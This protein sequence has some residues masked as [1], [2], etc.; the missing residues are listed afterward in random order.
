M[1][2]KIKKII[3]WL[4]AFLGIALGTGYLVEVSDLKTVMLV[5]V[6]AALI[7]GF[8]SLV[9]WLLFSDL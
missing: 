4:L 7:V 2:K 9:I 1:K 6:S 5:Y 3:G 8:I